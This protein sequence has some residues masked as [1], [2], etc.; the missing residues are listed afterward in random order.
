MTAIA[1]QSNFPTASA[2]PLGVPRSPGS[3]LSRV[4]VLLDRI[5]I[6]FVVPHGYQTYPYE[7][8]GDVDLL[9]D[10]HWLPHLPALFAAHREELGAQMVQWI[11]CGAQFLVLAARP[12]DQPP[13]LLQLHVSSAYEMAERVYYAAEEILETR[14]R[15][16][17]FFIPCASIEF[18]CILLNK[19]A[20]GKLTEAHQ[21][22]LTHLW[23]Q[24][25]PGCA[26]A[27][28]RWVGGR[29]VRLIEAAI[30]SGD[31]RAV[32]FEIP[33]LAKLTASR[34]SKIP[35]V[36]FIHRQ[37][38]RVGR[39]LRPNRGVHVV[40]LGPDGAGKSTIIERVEH[41]LRDAFLDHAYLTFAPG[42]IPGKFAAPKP[43]GPHSLPPRS[44]PASLAKA[45]WWL[46]CYTVG[47]FATVHPTRARGGLVVNHR[48]LVDAI[49]DQKRYRYNGPIKLLNAIWR[50]APKPDL[51]ILL[52]A[53]AE[54]IH[55]RKKEVA[56]EEIIRQRE[57]YK[58]IVGSLPYAHVVSTDRSI[59]AAVA[60]VESILLG[61]CTVR[62]QPAAPAKEGSA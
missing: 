48:Y 39:W 26:V 5:G 4:F 30:F 44:R 38:G 22:R 28:R 40:F 27:L 51:I 60:D 61:F 53:P 54:V 29:E 8:H 35:L 6:P 21:E 47:Y 31:W 36:E 2:T 57:G 59:D 3:L 19:L 52:D 55:S 24:D 18:C 37:T 32:Q 41:E 12:A 45:A 13:V 1:A 7:I 49:V 50:I 58:A 33:A 16:G 9:V 62:L 11:D 15:R 42:L 43:G 25:E 34:G 23:K 56:L 17:S 20:K 46:V 10:P 14:L